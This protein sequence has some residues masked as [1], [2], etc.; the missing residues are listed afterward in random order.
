LRLP[1]D[2]VVRRAHLQLF[3][4]GSDAAMPVLLVIALGCFSGALSMRAI[5]PVVPEIAR[6]LDTTAATVAMLASAFAFPYAL[7]Q[8]LLGPLSDALG[9]TRIIK[10]CLAVLAATLFASAMATSIEALF[11][12]RVLSGIAAGGIIPVGMAMVGDRFSIAER[13]VAI[14][15]IILA[16]VAGQ[17]TSSIGAG[18]LASFF[19][20]RFVLAFTGVVAAGV[21]IASIISLAP[22]PKAERQR[23]T[24]TGLKAGYKAI[25]S[26]PRAAICYGA[27][28]VEGIVVYGISPYVATLFEA[29]GIGGM[30]E[31][32]VVIAGIGI[33]GVVYAAL[34]RVLLKHLGGPFNVMRGG[35]IVAALGFSTIALQPAW[36]VQLMGFMLVGLGFFMIHNALQVQATELAPEARGSAVALHAFFF[37][38]GQAAG[39]VSYGLGFASIGVWATVMVSATAMLILGFLSAMGLERLAARP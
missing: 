24:M 26:N 9:K 34:V 20:W 23:F 30:R 25:F 32:G 14:S 1:A 33:G 28:A 10:V 11:V 39:P 16:A 31:A 21:L 29:Q 22:R 37:F 6:D 27:V 12:A 5:D 17:L 35:G 3:F 15:R 38:L 13:Q 18:F 36:P 19:G 7:G 8:P 4:A 2:F